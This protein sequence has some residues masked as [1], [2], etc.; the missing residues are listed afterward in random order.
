MTD[1]QVKLLTDGLEALGLGYNKDKVKQLL[2][3]TELLQKWN[4]VYSLT[5]IT[6][7]EHIITHHL[8]DGLTILPFITEGSRVID[9]GS[10]M[11]IPGV[12]LAIWQPQSY[13]MLLDS[14]HKKC[15]F[16]KQVIIEL[17]LNNV[18][19]NCSRVEDY[20]PEH[21]FDLAVSR[22]F[23]A[24]SLFITLTRH[25]VLESG[26]FIAMKSK[27]DVPVLT[28]HNDG[29]NVRQTEVFAEVEKIVQ[30]CESFKVKI[31]GI[32]DKRII[33]KCRNKI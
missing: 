2:I 24:T 12:V 27:N 1:E 26:H 14:N 13:I 31:P 9:I 3:Y 22:A 4:K 20:I 8:L 33:L 32:E 10:G 15:A 30:N 25:L 23:A 17:G 5:A 11:G 21:K 18:Q 7:T 6:Q 16:L 19:V 29:P 28:P